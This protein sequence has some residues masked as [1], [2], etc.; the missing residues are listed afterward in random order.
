MIR[1]KK[2]LKCEK[3]MGNCER[4]GKKCHKIEPNPSKDRAIHKGDKH[5]F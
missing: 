2:K 3:K 5:L 4:A 1:Q